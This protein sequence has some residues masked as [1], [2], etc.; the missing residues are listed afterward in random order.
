VASE[1]RVEEFNWLFAAER[2][3]SSGVD[4]ITSSLG[5]NTFDDPSMDYEKTE[6][7]GF[8]A[9]VTKAATAAIERGIVVVCSAGNEGNNSWGL[10]TPPADAVGI[11]SVGAVN[12]AGAR[13]PFSSRGPTA[14][15]RFKPDVM[16][17]GSGTMVVRP[18]GIIA[19]QTGTSV[20]A[21]IITCL[22][23]GLIQR[24]PELTGSEIY[25]AITESASQSQNPDNLMGYGIP[26][27]PK[28]RR[29]YVPFV[30]T[31]PITISPNPAG[32]GKFQVLFQEVYQEVQIEV[33]DLRG[34][35]LGNHYVALTWENNPLEID[36]SNL[37]P[38]SYLVRVRTK[39][40]FK[41]TTV[42]RL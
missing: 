25:D 24:F 41:T 40:N 17:L 34:T 30:P 21:P 20:A 35:V 18:N 6:L 4:V 23:A 39:D 1:F 27:Y 5:Y 11:L 22:A 9:I 38:G 13:S 31:E 15:G 2:A 19:T 10:V 7:D 36:L 3:D 28:V 33:F 8:T 29:Q 42:V 16:A 12:Q 32:N 26:Y 37:A 14:D